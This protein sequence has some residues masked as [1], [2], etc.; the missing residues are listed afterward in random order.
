MV[1]KFV[2]HI[3]CAALLAASVSSLAQTN[4][5]SQI[6][7]VNSAVV[8]EKQDEAAVRAAR[9]AHMRQSRLDQQHKAQIKE[10]AAVAARTK[11]QDRLNRIEAQKQA[12]EVQLESYQN[13]LREIDLQQKK[14]QLQTQQTRVSRENEAIDQ[15]LKREAAKTDLIQAQ[16]DSQRNLSEGSKSLMEDVGKAK[17]KDSGGWF[18]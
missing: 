12:R 13:Q 5:T 18:K 4:L 16:A 6:N 14:L 3:A 11:E 9:E 15:Q 17:V 1:R 7:A 2:V 10:R 8:K